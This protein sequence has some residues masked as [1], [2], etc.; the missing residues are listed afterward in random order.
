M[1]LIRFLGSLSFAVILIASLVILLILSTSLESALGTPFVQKTFYQN[2]WF[3]LFLSLLWI[4]IF[5]STWLRFPFK[6]HHTGFVVTHIGILLLLLGALLTRLIGIEG[7]MTLYEGEHTHHI[8]QEGHVLNVALPDHESQIFQLDPKKNRVP[9][10]LPIKNSAFKLFLTQIS[11]HVIPIQRVTEGTPQ[12]PDN[13]AI[14][15]TLSSNTVGLNET[16]WLIEKDPQNPHSTFTSIGPAQILLKVEK[17]LNSPSGLWLRLFRKSN[18]ELFSMELNDEILNRWQTSSDEEKIPIPQSDLVLSNIRYYPNAKVENNQLLN[19]PQE[20]PFNPAV[21]FEICN[22]QNQCEHHTKF[23]L[24]P[25]LD[26]LHGRNSAN[27]FDL[28]V[29]LEIPIP[30]TFQEPNPPSLVF[31]VSSDG[32]WHYHST[33]SKG[34]SIEGAVQ[35]SIPLSAGWMDIAFTVNQILTHAQSSKEIVE[36]PQGGDF[37]VEIQFVPSAS[38]RGEPSK[39]ELAQK[40]W[41]LLNQPVLLQTEAG[42]L[43]FTLTP[44]DTSLPFLLQLLDFR[45]VDYPGTQNPSSFESDI[46]LYDMK[47]KTTLQKTI[48]MNKPLDY[49]G[50]RIFQSSYIQDPSAGEASIFTVARNPGIPFIYSGA[51]ILFTGVVLLFYVKPFSKENTINGNS[52]K[53]A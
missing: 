4:N 50:F 31:F 43:E 13:Y 21:E 8:L 2:H 39:G 10:S 18:D 1:R 49:A 16:F 20:I 9:L 37:G 40:E 44:K 29:K 32:Q 27:F 33:S 28:S 23:T 51:V 52:A 12:D 24:F 14:Q 15:V 41:V 45:K 6:K 22:S 48:S 34:T 26:S 35:L 25:E 38:P 19:S 17:N 36:D 30:E 53:T 3:D 7:Q 46:L 47:E 5:C 42:A 11:E